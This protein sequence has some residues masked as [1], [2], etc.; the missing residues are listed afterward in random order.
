[1]RSAARQHEAST[2]FQL[3]AASD[4]VEERADFGREVFAARIDPKLPGIVSGAEP[5]SEPLLRSHQYDIR[6]FAKA[7]LSRS[8]GSDRFWLSTRF[9]ELT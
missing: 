2:V 5:G 3:S 4:E 8:F 9:A 1:M 6:Q 7:A